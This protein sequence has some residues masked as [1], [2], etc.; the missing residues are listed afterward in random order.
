MTCP[1]TEVVVVDVAAVPFD[2]GLAPVPPEPFVPAVPAA[3]SV[4]ID[5]EVSVR[6]TSTISPPFPPRPFEPPPPHPT[7]N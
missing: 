6:Y 3:T 4:T 1:A 2:P 5:P 7:P